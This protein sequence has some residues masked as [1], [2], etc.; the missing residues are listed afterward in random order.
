[1][2][3]GVSV[4]DMVRVGVTHDQLVLLFR[5]ERGSKTAAG[6][7]NRELMPLAHAVLSARDMKAAAQGQSEAQEG[8]E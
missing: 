8:V 4:G 1:M 7:T 3:H 5:F 6:L 2:V